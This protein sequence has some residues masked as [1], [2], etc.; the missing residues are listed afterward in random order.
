M[1]QCSVCMEDMASTETIV[2]LPECLHTFHRRDARVPRVD[3]LLVL[4]SFGL[5]NF[6]VVVNVTE[7][8]YL[9]RWLKSSFLVWRMQEC[10]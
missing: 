1:D 6:G 5:F 3:G 4:C 9:F 10:F 2:R 8:R 7:F